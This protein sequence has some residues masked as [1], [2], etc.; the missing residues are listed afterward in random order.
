MHIKKKKS[1]PILYTERFNLVIGNIVIV[2]CF[3]NN[4]FSIILLR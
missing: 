2:V 4:P 1:E 3:G